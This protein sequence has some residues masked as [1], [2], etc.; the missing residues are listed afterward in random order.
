[1]TEGLTARGV[2]RREIDVI[3]A[4]LD[5]VLS[6]QED[7]ELRL[8]LRVSGQKWTRKKIIKTGWKGV[9]RGIFLTFFSWV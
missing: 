7:V 8:K 9:W 3:L 6:R 5:R 2:T 4:E 1:M